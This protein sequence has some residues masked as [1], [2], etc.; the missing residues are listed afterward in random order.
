M[1]AE[2]QTR[3]NLPVVLINREGLFVIIAV[4]VIS[5]L[6]CAG[7]LTYSFS[8]YTKLKRNA[9]DV[10][11]YIVSRVKAADQLGGDKQAA[12]G[13]S[14][15][16]SADDRLA[17]AN[18]MSAP[19][20]ASDHVADTGLSTS[21]GVSEGRSINDTIAVTARQEISAGGLDSRLSDTVQ[22]DDSSNVPAATT[23][24]DAVSAANQG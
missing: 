23:A 12:D 24:T 16:T 17:T 3:V 8:N 11:G 1:D 19:A 10:R 4:L 9:E 21:I 22:G 20:A 15:V 7:V 14:G 6:G 2:I 13:A 5:I 18:V